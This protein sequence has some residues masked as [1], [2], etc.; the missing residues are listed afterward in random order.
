M[1]NSA[2]LKAEGAN[3][4]NQAYSRAFW[5]EI[6]NLFLGKSSEL[7]SFDEVKGRL[8]LS[9]EVYKGLEDVPLDRIVGSVGRYHDFTNKFLPK[10]KN[11]QSR[12]AN[13]YEQYNGMKGLPP[14][15]LYKVDDVYFVRDG[16]HRVSV[17]RQM[18]NKTIEAYVVELQTPI[19]LEPNMTE[20]QWRSAE[21]YA[22][23]LDETHLDITRPAQERII[24][25]EPSRY[26]DLLE[27]IRLYQSV[28]EHNQGTSLTLREAC[29][30]WYD[31]VYHPA[32]QLIRRYNVLKFTPDRTEGDL[33]LWIVENLRHIAQENN[34]KMEN[35]ALSDMLKKFLLAQNIPVPDELDNE[36]DVSPIK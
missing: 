33:Y 17:A 19:D 4:F 36:S 2:G 26:E 28:L 16:N 31:N 21:A 23:F 30:K 12:W 27:H 20:K 24:L 15:E 32:L 8:R 29:V 7:W 1:L 13:I 25:T 18:G 11:I 3:K 5:G 14:I 35:M 9:Q 10:K 34:I 6:V 22:H